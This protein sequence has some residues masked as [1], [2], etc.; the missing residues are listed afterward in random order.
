MQILIFGDDKSTLRWVKS[1]LIKCSHC[2]ITTAAGID[3]TMVLLKSLHFDAIIFDISFSGI[4]VKEIIRELLYIRGNI[5]LIILTAPETLPGAVE[6]VKMG[7]ETYL[8]KDKAAPG[9]LAESLSAV[10]SKKPRFS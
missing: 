4:K 10:C 3:E 2:Y 6:A 7:A 5:A 1:Q 9:L 8:V